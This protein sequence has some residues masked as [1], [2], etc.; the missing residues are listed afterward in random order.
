MNAI[1]ENIIS[2]QEHVRVH[3]TLS[4]SLIQPLHPREV[5]LLNYKLSN[6][7][8][9]ITIHG[10]DAVSEIPNTST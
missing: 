2:R 1:K 4:E 6:S 5:T 7:F 3:N 8:N 9:M 10:Y